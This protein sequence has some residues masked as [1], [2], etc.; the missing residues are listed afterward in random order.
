M[1][2]TFPQFVTDDVDGLM[3]HVIAIGGSAVFGPSYAED[4]AYWY[5]AFA[6]IDSNQAW[7]VSP[8]AVSD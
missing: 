6:D 1:N 3:A 5:G 7:V 2:T 8:E 4:G